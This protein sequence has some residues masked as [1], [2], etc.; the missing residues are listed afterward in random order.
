MSEGSHQNR[1]TQKDLEELLVDAKLTAAYGQ[2]AGRLRSGDI[3]EAIRAFESLSTKSWSSSEAVALQKA[4]NQAVAEIVPTTLLDIRDND[5][6][7]PNNKQSLGRRYGLICASILL[8]G[9]TAYFTVLYN[10]GTELIAR[11]ESVDKNKPSEKMAAVAREWRLA[12]F[13]GQESDAGETYYKMLDELREL[14][15]QVKTDVREYSNLAELMPLLDDSL[16]KAMSHAASVPAGAGTPSGT[17]LPGATNP[18]AKNSTANN[19]PTK[20]PAANTSPSTAPTADGTAAKAFATNASSSGAA[21]P[22]GM[23]PADPNDMRKNEPCGG[24]EPPQAA[25]TPFAVFMKEPPGKILSE[26][27][28]LITNFACAESLMIS[29]YTMPYFAAL[30]SEIKKTL[31]VYGLWILPALYGA[32]GAM[33]FYMRAVLNPVLTDPPIDKI[34]HRVALGGFVGIIFAWF[35]APTPDTMEKFVGLTVNSFAIAFLIGFSID[36][37]FA[38]LDKLVTFLQGLINEPRPSTPPPKQG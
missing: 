2:R 22:P 37:F 35:W 14:D 9:I 25:D 7:N 3:F 13:E 23:V 32:L 1:D 38:L 16:L 27:K 17:G 24:G 31:N 8:M 12:K 19:P 30:G 36:V 21:A 4:F 29:P 6:F 5:P 26:N 10:Q 34:V 20:P 28:R 15:S 11:L 18:A 33:I